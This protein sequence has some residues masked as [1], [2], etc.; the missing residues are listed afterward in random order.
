MLSKEE[1]SFIQ[2]HQNDD[3]F[4]LALQKS[5]FPNLDLPKLIFQIQSKSKHKSKL[6][7]WSSNPAICLPV[8]LSLEQSSSEATALFKAQFISGNIADLTGGM[9][10]DSWAFAQNPKNQ[11]SYFEINTDLAALTKENHSILNISSIQHY[12]Q[13]GISF[14]Q[15]NYKKFDWIY[16]DPARRGP[17]GEKVFLLKDC[18]PNVTETLPYLKENTGLL[19]KV[20]PMLDID[21]CIKELNGVS[22]VHIVCIQNEIKELLF[23]KKGISSFDPEIKIWDLSSPEISVFCGK[24]STEKNHEIDYSETKDFLYEPHVGILKAGF[25]KSLNL[26]NIQKIQT[27]THLYTS[28][29]EISNFPGRKFKVLGKGNLDR[30]WIEKIVPEGKI[31][32]SCRNFPLKP[33]EIRKKLKYQEGGNFYLFAYKNHNNI[34]ELAI[35]QK[36]Y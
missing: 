22:E 32:I 8:Q 27:N 26:Y 34:P 17:K 29:S 21:L 7:I 30:K 1:I 4:Q 9:G 18:T 3:L 23:I 6:P 5:K 31:N 28:A 36:T 13:D 20:S 25:F 2:E 16:L 33:E 35:C 14:I 11:I 19:L 10:I 24:K 12:N 15:D